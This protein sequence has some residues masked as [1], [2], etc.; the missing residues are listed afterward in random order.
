MASGCTLS[1]DDARLRDAP[2]LGPKI[3][4]MVRAIGTRTKVAGML[5]ITVQQLRRLIAGTSRPSM[6]TLLKLT[7]LS[8]R[9][10]DWVIEGDS[11]AQ[12]ALKTAKAQTVGWAQ[13]GTRVF[14]RLR[15]AHVDVLGAEPEATRLHEV[16]GT[17]VALVFGAR[18]GDGDVELAELAADIY[19]GGLNAGAATGRK[20]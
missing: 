3:D 9:G 12:V 1:K 7:E 19:S 2:S 14:E 15:R 11:Q 6:R 10:L 5:G 8:G 20:R 16:A 13:L 4:E 18:E 17:V